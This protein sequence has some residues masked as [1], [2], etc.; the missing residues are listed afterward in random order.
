MKIL[1]QMFGKLKKD[2]IKNDRNWVYLE[3]AS[4]REK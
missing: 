1:R 4:I 3:R 2:R